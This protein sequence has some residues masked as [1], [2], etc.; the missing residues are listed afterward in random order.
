[1][2]GT[3]GGRREGAGRPRGDTSTHQQR[4]T[5]AR[6]DREEAVAKLRRMEAARVTG[7]LIPADVV[8][9]RWQ[10]IAANVRARLLAIPT[11]VAAETA[12]ATTAAECSR[13]LEREIHHVLEELTETPSCED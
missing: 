8:R 3:H 11:A 13:I 2:T 9:E 5:K 1:M 12:A 7:S 10:L 6:A 4:F